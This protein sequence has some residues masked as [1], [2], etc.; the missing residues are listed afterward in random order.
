MVKFIELPT[1]LPYSSKIVV[2]SDRF[3]AVEGHTIVAYS[4]LRSVVSQ[5]TKKSQIKLMQNSTLK[6][7]NN[8]MYN[9]LLSCI[10][11]ANLCL[12]LLEIS[13]NDIIKNQGCAI[14]L[15]DVHTTNNEIKR[16]FLKDNLIQDTIASSSI[17]IKRSS[18]HI[19]S[20]EITNGDLDGIFV[21]SNRCESPC[22]VQILSTIS[23]ENKGNGITVSDFEG[24]VDL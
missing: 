5:G 24:I 10:Q 12:K 7:S 9:G 11:L 14:E 18:C 19:E 16:V 1:L 13:K 6:I 17:Y 21:T 22:I 15:D 8:K 3:V 4:K 20:N 2:S 23:K